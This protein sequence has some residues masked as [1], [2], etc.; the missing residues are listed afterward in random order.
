MNVSPLTT[1]ELREPAAVRNGS[2]AVKQAYS[3]AQG[4]EEMLLQQL[5]QSLCAS[6]GLGGE[7]AEGESSET[8]Q[9]G[10]SAAPAGGDMLGSLM[11]QTLTESLMRDGGIGL[12]PQLMRTL[13]PSAAR[14]ASAT[15]AHVAGGTP[16]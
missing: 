1:S 15:S 16:A 10:G 4:F 2:S 8:A 11:P 9:E 14:G 13:D 3:T 7:G 5:S 12:A 6:A